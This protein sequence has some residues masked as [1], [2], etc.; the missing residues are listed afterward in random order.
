MTQKLKVIPTNNKLSI[1]TWQFSRSMH[2]QRILTLM[3]GLT[4]T[5]HNGDINTSDN[6]CLPTAHFHR[7]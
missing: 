6:V 4:Y 1:I 5:L 3:I 2:A 7:L